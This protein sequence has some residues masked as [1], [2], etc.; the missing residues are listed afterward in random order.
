MSFVWTLLGTIGQLMLA[1]F[2]FMLVAFS[3]GGVANGGELSRRQI[4]I[5]DLSLL[6]LPA[7]CV[8]SAVIVVGLHVRGAGA[9]SYGW[10]AMPLAATVAYVIYVTVLG[11]RS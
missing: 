11:R 4:A 9:R 5:L 6:G 3:G 10:Y 8:V 7:L 2:L 1:Y